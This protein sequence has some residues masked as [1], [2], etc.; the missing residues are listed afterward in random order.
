MFSSIAK[1]DW[2]RAAIVGGSASPVSRL[3][4]SGFA[5]SRVGEVTGA[6]Y[7]LCSVVLTCNLQF[8]CLMDLRVFV[9]GA[10]CLRL[11]SL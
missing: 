6:C 4:V 5:Y 7:T 11:K 1:A 9:G 2:V 8:R 3:K 10:N